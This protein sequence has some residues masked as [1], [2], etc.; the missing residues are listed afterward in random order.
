MSYPII[1]REMYCE[2]CFTF[3]EATGRFVRCSLDDPTDLDFTPEPCCPECGKREAIDADDAPDE[4]ESL[5]DM[6][7]DGN[8][9]DFDKLYY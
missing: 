8:F 9:D 3:F 7:E 5:Q 1:E 6:G 2:Y 4:E